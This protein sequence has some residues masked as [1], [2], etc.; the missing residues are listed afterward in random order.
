MKETFSYQEKLT[1][2]SIILIPILITQLAMFSMTFFDIMM[3][4]NFSADHLAGVAVG[5]SLWVPIFTGLS[6]ILLSITPIVAQLAGAQKT[7][8]VSFSV[9]QG[10]Y[11]AIALSIFVIVIGYF[12]LDPLLHFMNLEDDVRYVAKHYLVGISF[13]I[14]PVFVYTVLRSFID[15]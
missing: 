7:K 10:I 2:L 4:G 12:I 14:I 9:V 5:S 11:A 8:G 1:Q 13:G 6:G 15:A 3:T